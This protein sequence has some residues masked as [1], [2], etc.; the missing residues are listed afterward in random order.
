MSK[1][2]EM[3]K[4]NGYTTPPR[5][6]P[7]DD[8]PT[9]HDEEAHIEEPVVQSVQTVQPASPQ[10]ISRARLV[11]VPKRIPPKLP[12]RNPN[13]SGPIIIDASPKDPSTE[14]AAS[15]E[16][17]HDSAHEPMAG[18]DDDVNQVKDKTETTRLDDDEDDEV[19][20]TNPWAKV[21]ETRKLE[22]E[23]VS[24]MPGGFVQ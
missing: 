7:L 14:W 12:P 16:S 15:N 9:D 8:K 22:A 10:V 5:T 18:N 21:E 2:S 19:M 1:L 3:S 6:P 23:Q 13:R 20:K 24:T 4:V 17:M 11:D